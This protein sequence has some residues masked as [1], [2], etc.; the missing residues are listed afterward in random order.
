MLAFLCGGMEYAPDGGRAWRERIRLWLQENLNHHVYDPTVEARRI[1]TPEELDGLEHLGRPP[2]CAGDRLDVDGMGAAV[3]VE[4]VDPYRAVHTRNLPARP[5]EGCRR[6]PLPV[7]RL[8]HH[9]G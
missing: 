7:H 6:E 4:I 2:S 3:H 8:I 9:G 5:V 1:L